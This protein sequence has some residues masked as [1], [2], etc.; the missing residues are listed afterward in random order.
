MWYVWRRIKTL[1]RRVNR[2]REQNP[3]HRL[4]PMRNAKH[5]AEARDKNGGEGKDREIL[6]GAGV[7]GDGELEIRI[8]STKQMKE[9][10]TL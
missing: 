9:S 8:D 1:E 5:K 3:E 4:A 10:M 6:T 2:N 7:F